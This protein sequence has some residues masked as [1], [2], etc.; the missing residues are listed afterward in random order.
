MQKVAHR[1][2]IPTTRFK[3]GQ[4]VT[5]P[6]NQSTQASFPQKSI[7]CPNCRKPLPRCAVC[8]QYLGTPNT[9]LIKSSDG[10]GEYGTNY[11]KWFN[12]C[13][14]CNHGTHAGHAKEWFS[15]HTLC[16]VPEC[17][18]K[19]AL[20]FWILRCTQRLICLMYNIGLCGVFRK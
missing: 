19:S 4:Q 14:V 17:E 12:F 6:V 18:C 7:V 11:D 8:L 10:A 13:L 20:T 3:D 15:K 2:E 9:R 16:P 1:S 5:I